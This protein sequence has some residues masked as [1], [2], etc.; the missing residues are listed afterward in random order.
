[1]RSHAVRYATLAA[2]ILVPEM[3]TSICGCGKA[4][5]AVNRTIMHYVL[6]TFTVQY[7]VPYPLRM[8]PTSVN[9]GHCTVATIR[10]AGRLRGLILLEYC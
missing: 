9:K 4:T 5:W 8:R 1:M 10:T 3:A 2:A 6:R 7:S